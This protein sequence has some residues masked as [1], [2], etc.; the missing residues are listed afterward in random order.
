MKSGSD[1][2]KAKKLKVDNYGDVRQKMSGE[3]ERDNLITKAG[4][5]CG[6]KEQ[7]REGGTLSKEE[8]CSFLHVLSSCIIMCI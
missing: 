3:R 6:D 4:V 8:V 5:K 1:E 2:G 7:E